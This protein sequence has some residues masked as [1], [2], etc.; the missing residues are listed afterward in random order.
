M[1]NKTDGIH[2]QL[3][4]VAELIIDDLHIIYGYNCFVLEGL[5]S[6]EQQK[7]NVAK[8]VSKTLNSLHI[9]GLA[10]D[11]VPLN[12]KNQPYWPLIKDIFWKHLGEIAQKHG[13]YSLFLDKGWDGPHLE[14]RFN[15]IPS[16]L[17]DIYNQSKSL[18]KFYI[19][20]SK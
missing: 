11:I 12:D 6:I 20:V 1:K 18:P 4:V 13:L 3:Q 15:K 16:R 2:P 5:R 7:E 8:G 17:R 14:M 10:V 19:D 9:I